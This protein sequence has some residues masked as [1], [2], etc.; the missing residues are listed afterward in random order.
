MWK[1]PPERVLVAVDFGE[2]STGALG[3][4]GY[5]ASAFGAAV[6][7][8]H[9]ERFEPPPYF[10]L[11]QIA[12]LETERRDAQALAVDHL[13]RFA[14]AVTAYPIEPIVVDEPPAEAILHAAASGDLIVMGTHGR[15]GPGRWWLGSV[16]ERV[17]RHAVV[18]VLVTRADA[19]TG[20]GV[21]DRIL[22]VGGAAAGGPARACVDRLAGTFGS[23][24]VAGGPVA[25]CGPDA[26]RDASLVAVAVE[27]GAR[28]PLA[29]GDPE[30]LLAACTRPVL[31]I[32]DC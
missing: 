9:A 26:A 21:F 10:T 20:A 5:V 6:T 13:R 29:A 18:P 28:A 14:A 16:A 32:P 4:A 24:V 3:I 15:R 25:H 23:T 31:F 19:A 27:S 7:V 1:C 2:A 12:R 11:D 17:V 22:L 8:L 30:S